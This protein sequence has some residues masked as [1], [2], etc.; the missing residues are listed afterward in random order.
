[1]HWIE[2]AKNNFHI[3]KAALS[4]SLVLQNP[5]FD[6]PFLVQRD[7]PESFLRIPMVRSI[8]SFAA[9][10]SC[11]QWNSII[12]QPRG[13]HWPL[14]GLWRSCATTSLA[15]VSHWLTNTHPSNGSG[16]TKTPRVRLLSGFCNCRASPFRWYTTLTASMQKQM[17]SPAATQMVQGEAMC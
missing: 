16:R 17:P 13:K 9:A 5:N 8:P 6:L 12:W 14:S 3:L 11:S 15:G 4:S 7:G 2:H 10:I 1:M